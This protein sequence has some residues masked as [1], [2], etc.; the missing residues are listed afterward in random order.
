MISEPS[1]HLC[2]H[3]EAYVTGLV[4]VLSGG[5]TAGVDEPSP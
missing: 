1:L 3:Q 5:G 2:P 4:M